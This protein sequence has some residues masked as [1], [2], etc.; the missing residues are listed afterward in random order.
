M[1]GFRIL[2]ALVEGLADRFHRVLSF[3]LLKI[4]YFHFIFSF[5]KPCSFT[6]YRYISNWRGAETHHHLPWH[7]ISLS[8]N[9]YTVVK[10]CNRSLQWYCNGIVEDWLQPSD[11]YG[12]YEFQQHTHVYLVQIWYRYHDN[13]QQYWYACKPRPYPI[14]FS[15]SKQ[16]RGES[17][18][19]RSYPETRMSRC[20]PTQRSWPNDRR[21]AQKR[22]WVHF[23]N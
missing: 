21:P 13:I 8:N 4:D 5:L 10:H 12:S 23:L 19:A 18:N 15:R 22:V 7:W 14:L 9:G 1:K 6:M 2:I 16:H 20:G 11:C 17:G 3:P